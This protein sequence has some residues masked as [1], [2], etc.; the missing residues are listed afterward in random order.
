[1]EIGMGCAS[2]TGKDQ[3]LPTKPTL[4][5]S[6]LLISEPSSALAD[7]TRSIS[8]PPPPQALLAWAGTCPGYNQ[9]VF[10]FSSGQNPLPHSERCDLAE[11]TPQLVQAEGA[12][13]KLWQ[14]SDAALTG[15][16]EQGTSRQLYI[17]LCKKL[18]LKSHISQAHKPLLEKKGTACGLKPRFSL[19]AFKLMMC[20]LL[21]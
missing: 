15:C 12:G 19:N 6:Q 5:L 14:C 18:G 10:Q 3:K 17:N 7:P 9:T 16:S 2:H 4:C 13:G 11:K 21:S 20:P 8:L 1:M